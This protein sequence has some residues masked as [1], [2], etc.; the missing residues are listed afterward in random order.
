[1]FT[2]SA[3]LK[4][5]GLLILLSM[6]S[7]SCSSDRL[8]TYRLKASEELI[9]PIDSNTNYRTPFL[10]YHEENGIPYLAIENRYL[11]GIQFYDLNRKQLA[12]KTLFDREGENSLGGNDIG[13]FFIQSFDSIYVNARKKRQLCLADT[14]ATILGRYDI[15]TADSLYFTITGVT[16]APIAKKKEHLFLYVLADF[17]IYK[18]PASGHPLELQYDL[19]NG[20]AEV[21]FRFPDIYKGFYGFWHT[22]PCR[23]IADGSLVYSFPI[24][25]T[26]YALDVRR[27]KVTMHDGLG[28][29]YISHSF[30]PIQELHSAAYAAYAVENGMYYE[31][32]YDPYREVYYRFVL[33]PYATVDPRTGEAITK[34]E[35]KPFSVQ[36]ISTGFK[37]LGETLFPPD[38]YYQTNFFIAPEGLYLSNNNDWNPEAQEDRLSFTLFKLQAPS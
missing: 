14:S 12:F 1:M 18:E 31:I 7:Y 23:T 10:V 3:M 6:C 19:S 11:N 27:R 28:S 21:I 13:G 15:S 38:R 32:V 25:P 5:E 30:E 22:H 29:R 20:E 8:E 36:I 37:L 35:R 26:V 4:G 24:S 16:K 33:H 2:L 17:P 9:I 34:V